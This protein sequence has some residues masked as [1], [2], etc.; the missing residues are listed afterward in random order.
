VKTLVL[1]ILSSLSTFGAADSDVRAAME[2][3]KQALIHRD[4]AALERL[5]NNDLTYTHSAGL[6]ETKA[7]VIQSISSGKSVIEKLEYSNTTVRVYGDTALVK[8][9]VDLWHSPTDVVH[10]D[11]LHVWVR[12]QGEWRLAARQATRLAK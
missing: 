7:D 6:A 10:M 3:L 12:K 11:V 4:G 1:L 2:L 9:R 8:G 5:L